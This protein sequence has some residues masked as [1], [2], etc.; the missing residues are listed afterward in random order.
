MSAAR[1]TRSERAALVGLISGHARRLEAERS[2]DELAG[3]AEAAGAAVVLRVLQERPKPDP[4]TFLGAG[5]IVTLGASCAETD[6]DVVIFDHELTPAQLRH[7]EEAVHRKII[8]RTQLI[9]D[10]FARR[11]RTREGKL[12]V[13]L[14]QLKYLLPR[15]VGAGDALSRLGGGIG[16][17]GPGETKLETDRPRIRTRIH[18]I[19]EGIEHVRKRRS[20]P[21]QRRPKSAG[22][23]VAV[24]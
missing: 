6:T 1:V 20:Q 3:L 18:A 15:L 7:I 9:L 4:S 17:R 13:E 24:L 12:Q 21:R 16:T 5:K 22:P 11:A 23:T 2:L 14:A 8:D 10:I 19:S